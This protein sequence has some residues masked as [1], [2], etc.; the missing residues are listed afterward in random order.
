LDDLRRR[1][2]P[3]TAR[4]RLRRE[5]PPS[6]TALTD[7]PSSPEGLKIEHSQVS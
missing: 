6:R 4:Q 1:H 2:Q 3:P 5:I 7:Q